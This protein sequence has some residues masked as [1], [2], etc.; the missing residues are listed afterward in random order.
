MIADVICQSTWDW[1]G[2][3]YSERRE[4][5]ESFLGIE[6]DGKCST[7]GL[8]VLAVWRA[9]K[10]QHE[11]L[12]R[13]YE[14]G[15]AVTWIRRI[16]EDFGAICSPKIAPVPGAVLA[17]HSPRPSLDDHFEVLLEVPYLSDWTALHGGGGRADCGVSII[18]NGIRW[19][20]GRPLQYWIDPNSL[21]ESI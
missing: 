5:L 13:P 17:Y 21:I 7:C 20:S 11:L 16:A 2:A 9:A 3:S 15:K 10:V 1:N 18:S 14:T 6:L 8:F 4:D 19:N 12:E